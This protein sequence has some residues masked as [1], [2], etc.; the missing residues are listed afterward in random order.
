MTDE[1]RTLRMLA[2]KHSFGLKAYANIRCDD[3]AST[4]L[5]LC[6]RRSK[7]EELAQ[8]VK[9]LLV[10]GVDPSILDARGRTARDIVTHRIDHLDTKIER[11]ALIAARELLPSATSAFS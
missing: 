10:I 11:Q 1:V 7:H 3:V 6:C 2:D 4:A 5:H 9:C 8:R